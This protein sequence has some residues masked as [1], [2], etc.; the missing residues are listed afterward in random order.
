MLMG[1]QHIRAMSPV[2]GEDGNANDGACA[3]GSSE[4]KTRAA[5]SAAR[6]RPRAHPHS[7]CCPCW[8]KRC[9][10]RC[11]EEGMSSCWIHLRAVPVKHSAF[12][13][14]PGLRSCAHLQY[15]S[16]QSTTSPAWECCCECPCKT[17]RQSWRQSIEWC[18]PR[19][20]RRQQRS[21]S[22]S[23][24]RDALLEEG[25]VESSRNK[26]LSAFIYTITD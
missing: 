6:R 13:A 22:V 9:C 14:G 4:G 26:E 3:G 17:A 20:R 2:G 16:C 5:E 8:M 11:S 19:Q 21:C 18:L 10:I 25:D 7:T 12:S 15:P 24:V 1:Q 23:P